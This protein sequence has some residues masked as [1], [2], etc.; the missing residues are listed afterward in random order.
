MKKQVVTVTD[1]I[2]CD[3]TGK[4]LAPDEV[5][6]RTLT[7]RGKKLTLDLHPDAA[8]ELA[9]LEAA[10]AEAVAELDEWI[11]GLR[12]AKNTRRSPAKVRPAPTPHP[13]RR[14]RADTLKVREW[15]AANGHPEYGP[16]KRGR[17]PVKIVTE[18]EAAQEA[19]A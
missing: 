5:V 18:Y 10:H 7:H 3:K 17:V 16:G 8:G 14:T 6:Q 9:E 15:A 11:D 12:V 4:D 13:N 19:T 1:Q 2:V